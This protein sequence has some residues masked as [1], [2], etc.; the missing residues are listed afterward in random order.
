MAPIIFDLHLV[1]TTLRRRVF[2]R[3]SPV[4]VVCDE[5]TGAS[6]RR[7]PDFTWNADAPAGESRAPTRGK[8]DAGPPTADFS[9][10]ICPFC[11]VKG[12]T[13]LKGRSSASIPSMGLM[14]SSVA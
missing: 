3:H 4:F 12:M 10:V 5:R 8:K 14:G 13:R 1:Q 11:T 2:H 6:A 7:H 9:P